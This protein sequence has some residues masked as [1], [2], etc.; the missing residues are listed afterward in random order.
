MLK[1]EEMNRFTAVLDRFFTAFDEE[2]QQFIPGKDLSLSF[3]HEVI[4]KKNL[5]ERKLV[6]KKKKRQ[7]TENASTYRKI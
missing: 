5:F 4:G 7:T 6:S 2:S 1:E 3:P